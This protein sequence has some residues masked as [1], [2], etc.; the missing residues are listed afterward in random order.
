MS[1][2]PREYKKRIDETR[3]KRRKNRNRLLE[4]LQEYELV[5]ERFKTKTRKE[6]L[7]NFEKNETAEK[8]TELYVKI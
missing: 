5:D 8:S 6:I 2:T 7:E 1:E 3:E 4:C